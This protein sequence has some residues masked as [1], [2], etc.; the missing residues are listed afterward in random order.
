MEYNPYL[1][2]ICMSNLKK[3]NVPT[4]YVVCGMAQ[5][6]EEYGKFDVFYFN[7]PFQADILSEVLR[8]IYETHSGRECRCYYLNPTDKA[9]DEAFLNNGFKLVKVIEDPAE[10][11][12]KMNVYSNM[13]WD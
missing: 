13:E 12:F 6:Y 11:Y 9:K 5:D 2:D 4:E 1:Y 10:S 3:D 8:K 7:N